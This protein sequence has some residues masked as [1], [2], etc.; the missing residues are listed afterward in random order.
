MLPFYCVFLTSSWPISDAVCA[1]DACHHPIFFM[2]AV[3]RLFTYCATGTTAY[4]N[5]AF[6]EGGGTTVK[7]G[8]VTH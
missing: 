1:F 3:V 6:L 5:G 8:S 7:Q 4:G 2:D